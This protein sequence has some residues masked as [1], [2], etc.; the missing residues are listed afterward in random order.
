MRRI[1][2]AVLVVMMLVVAHGQPPT[3]LRAAD[4]QRLADDIRR[5]VEPLTARRL[6]SHRLDRFSHLVR[7]STWT[8]QWPAPDGSIAKHEVNGEIWTDAITAA[9]REDNGVF[10]PKRDKAYY[11]DS[12]IVLRSGQS[13]T[14]DSKAEIRLKPGVNTCMVRNEHIVNSQDKPVDAGTKPDT[15]ILIEGGIWTTL[16]TSRRQWNGNTRGRADA[17][18]TVPGCHGVLL[19]S[20]IRGVQ[21]RNVTIRQ[22]RA[23]GVHLSNC[24]EFLV[25]GVHFEDHGRDGV[26]INGPA[27]YGVI[28]NIR[29]VTHDDLIA[30]NAWEWRNYTPTFGA[31]HHVLVEDVLGAPL[32]RNAT[33]AI[34]LL[35]GVKL[36]TTGGR[37]NCPISDIVL[38]RISDLREFKLY[39]QPNLEVGRDKDFSAELGRIRNLHIE[40]LRFTRP[41]KIQ[42]AANV[43]IFG[44]D[45]VDLNCELKPGFKLVE[46]G[47][48]SETYKHG[49]SDPVKW[50]EI[51]SPDR[52]VIV[53]GFHLTNVRTTSGGKR[54]KV[55]K[56]EAVLVSIADQQLNPNYPATTPRGGTGKARIQ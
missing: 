42:I 53:R 20:N 35:P 24:T 47:P 26:H 2:P 7:R 37:L 50:V 32:E 6:E 33:D 21:V 4:G 11:L 14:A 34:R 15:D 18:D 12:P 8:E 3:P 52:D 16:A 27:S 9:L 19:L 38:R 56:P 55:P 41:G 28:R 31:I 17:K 48:M 25:D 36:F 43:E 40:T 1:L 5:V 22:S 23:F 10:I 54:V 30:L 39:D 51:F 44:I 29:G 45:D 49:S 46:I 13:L